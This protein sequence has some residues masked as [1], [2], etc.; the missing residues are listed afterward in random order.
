MSIL[1]FIQRQINELQ[2]QS[3]VL[4]TVVTIV[5]YFGVWN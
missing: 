3:G 4:E 1:H 5:D 2:I